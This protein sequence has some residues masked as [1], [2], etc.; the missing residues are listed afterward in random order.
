MEKWKD[1]IPGGLADRKKPSDFPEDA[2]SKGTEVEFEHTDDRDTAKEI[3]MDHLVEDVDYYDF[4]EQMEREMETGDMEKEGKPLRRAAKSKYP[5]SE[6]TPYN[7]WAVCTDSTGREDK[8]KY[9]R[10]VKHVKEKN[11]KQNR[12]KKRKGQKESATIYFDLNIDVKASQQ[13][14]LRDQGKEREKK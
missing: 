5:K 2:V 8:D 3:A 13:T 11:K 1:K 7:P 4:L 9:E 10:C 12:E 14:G 6:T